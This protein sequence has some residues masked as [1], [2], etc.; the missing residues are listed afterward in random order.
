ML[1]GKIKFLKEQKGFGFITLDDDKGVVFVRINNI[2]GRIPPAVGSSVTCKVRPGKKGNEAYDVRVIGGGTKTSFP[3]GFVA[4]KGGKATPEAFHDR[5]EQG[6]FDVAF[7]VSWTTVTP[8][9][10]APCE[11][12]TQHASAVRRDGENIGYNKRWLMINNRLAIS[13]FTVKGAIANEIGNLLGGCYRVPDRDEGHKEGAEAGTYP[14]TGAWKRYRVSMNG[15]SLPGIIREI[16]P[17]T[18]HV[19]V[20]PVIEYY[21]EVDELPE[22]LEVGQLCQAAWTHPEKKRRLDRNKRFITPG[23]IAPLQP[24][25]KPLHG[26][27]ALVY[28]GPYRFGMNLSLGPKDLGK[29]HHHRFYEKTGESITGTLPKLAFA[30]LDKMLDKVY[31]GQ[32]CKGDLKELKPGDPRRDLLGEP[33]YES[34]RDLSPGDWCYYTAF[35]DENGD[36]KVTAIGKCFQFKAV[37]RHSDTLEENTTCTEIDHLCPRCSIFGLANKSENGDKGAVGYA[38]RFRAATLVTDFALTERKV[39]GS[40]PMKETLSPQVVNFSE[41]SDG[42]RVIAKQ[43]ALP[44]LGPPKPSKRDVDGYF[45]EK[46]GAAKGA[47]RYHHA[48]LNFDDTLPH[49]VQLADKKKV[50]EEGLPYAHQMRPIGVVCREGISFKGTLGIENASAREVAALLL[51][52]E[53]RTLDHGF[54]LG[55]GKSIG[56]G[57]VA[58]SLRRIYVRRSGTYDWNSI[59]VPEDCKPQ[60]MLAILKQ[61]LPEVVDEIKRLIQS[62]ETWRKLH[63]LKERKQAL[64]FTKAGWNYWRNAKV[65]TF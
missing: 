11:D 50:T 26:Q 30:S 57:S 55:L 19:K 37:F 17:E 10:L 46:T 63:A 49:L 15:K 59:D 20:E 29:K 60:E 22:C 21:L 58:S 8:T 61:A 14:Y 35:E 62:A 4:R 41:W 5:L 32:F 65:E 40:I 44:I 7:D 48:D 53:N 6:R 43:F 34:L 54:K 25:Q 16:D 27:T 51:L 9:A 23:S 12:T 64:A 28:Y 1:S 2:D 33:W 24:G 56:L 45:K 52:L 39:K 3:Y 36:K 31:G 18:G 38:G 42:N 13:A 47:K